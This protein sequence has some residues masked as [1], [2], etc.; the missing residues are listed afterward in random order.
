MNTTDG[1]AMSHVQCAM[2]AA[3]MSY[4]IESLRMEQARLISVFDERE[5]SLL[6]EIERLKSEN[7]DTCVG[8]NDY[9]GQQLAASQAREKQLQ[10]D[11]DMFYSAWR[12]G[13]NSIT[14]YAIELAKRRHNTDTSALSTIVAKAGEV[15][16]QRCMKE[17]LRLDY[18]F[19]ADA[20]RSLREVKLDDIQAEGKKKP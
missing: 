11:L 1:L 19:S 12:A 10:E 18:W 13:C 16:R 6:A 4:E 2:V 15:M 17:L 20:L 8:L 14:I 9:F 7:R 3:D 5:A